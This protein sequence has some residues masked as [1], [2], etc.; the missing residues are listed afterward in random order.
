MGC[1]C[2]YSVHLCRSILI[3]EKRERLFGEIWQNTFVTPGKKSREF[4]LMWGTSTK[5]FELYNNRWR[6]TKSRRVFNYL[7]SGWLVVSSWNE[8]SLLLGRTFQNITL[9]CVDMWPQKQ[10]NKYRKRRA[11]K[12]NLLDNHIWK[13]RWF[14][15]FWANSMSKLCWGVTGRSSRISDSRSWGSNNSYPLPVATLYHFCHSFRLAVA[16]QNLSSFLQI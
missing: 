7:F 16:L 13:S 14:K 2:H 12:K 1:I 9:L 10:Q 5:R 8:C 3:F 4:H 11:D 6:F 15:T